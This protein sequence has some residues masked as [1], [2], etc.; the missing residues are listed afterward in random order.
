M[1]LNKNILNFNHI[2]KTK[3]KEEI[4]EIEQLY[5]YYHYR[6]WCYQKAY[7]YFRNLNEYEF[8]WFNSNRDRCG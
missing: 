2:D 7:K 4:A 8:N 1:S 3:T 5:K 6:F